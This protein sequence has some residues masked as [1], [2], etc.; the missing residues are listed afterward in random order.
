MNHS[1]FCS[2]AYHKLMK[3]TIDVTLDRAYGQ[4]FLE[5]M[6]IDSTASKHVHCYMASA[7]HGQIILTFRNGATTL[8]SKTMY[9]EGHLQLRI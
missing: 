2:K 9:P 5:M 1:L 4:L 7:Y 3:L 8:H 6:K